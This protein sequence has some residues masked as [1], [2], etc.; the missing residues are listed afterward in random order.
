MDNS[1]HFEYIVLNFNKIPVK[2]VK[3]AE[4]E[5]NIKP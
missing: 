1:F 3:E 4:E 2:Y 5:D